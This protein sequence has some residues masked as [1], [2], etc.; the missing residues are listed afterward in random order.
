M[1][2][3]AKLYNLSL[4][5]SFTY[6]VFDSQKEKDDWNTFPKVFQPHPRDGEEGRGNWEPKKISKSSKG[7]KR[8]FDLRK[9]N[10]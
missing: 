10:F 5:L 1:L 8:S 3:N 4:W 9:R 2:R 6:L 7:D